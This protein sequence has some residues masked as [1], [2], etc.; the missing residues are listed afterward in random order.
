M[1]IPKRIIILQ[2][3]VTAFHLLCFQCT[4]PLLI[5]ACCCD[6]LPGL[7]YITPWHLLSLD[8]SRESNHLW[9][10]SN[11]L[12]IHMVSC[13]K[14]LPASSPPVWEQQISQ[15][16]LSAFVVS[17]WVRPDSVRSLGTYSDL[18]YHDIWCGNTERGEQPTYVT[19]LDFLVSNMNGNIFWQQMFP[20]SLLAIISW[21]QD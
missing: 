2:P 20:C 14:R 1:C 17:S 21:A 4:A 7:P 9:N 13:D 16:G 18:I 19:P 11:Y 12:T 5:L 10:V 3:F 6:H 8:Y 15:I